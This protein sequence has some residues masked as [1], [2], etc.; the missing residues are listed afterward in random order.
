MR[1]IS[2]RLSD[3]EEKLISLAMQEAGITSRSEFIRE[4]IQYYSIKVLGIEG[5]KETFEKIK[6]K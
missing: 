3:L 1:I 4:A 2:V 6:N 5:I